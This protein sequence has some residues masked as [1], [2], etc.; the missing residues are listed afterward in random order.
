MPVSSSPTPLADKGHYAFIFPIRPGETRFQLSYR[1]PYTGS[2]KFQPHVYTPTET[3]AVM[4]PKGMSF[5]QGPSSGYQPDNEDV[6]VQTFV[7]K[8][9]SPS[10]P[11]DFTVSG[12]G[13]MPRE[14]QAGQNQGAET[15]ANQSGS[16]AT[17]Q[18]A[19]TSTASDTRPGGG[20]GAP[21]DSPDP[22]KKYRG[23]ILGGLSIVLAGAAAFMLRGKPA[24]APLGQANG[25]LPA[26]P[27]SMQ[28]AG[29]TL[30][31]P[32]VLPG[33]LGALKDELFTLETERLEGKIT[34]AEYAQAKS[35]L[36]VVLR[37]ALARQAS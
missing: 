13:S 15:A 14:E 16:D 23:W 17:G 26:K 25:S 27:L 35:A 10:Q 30:S 1:I 5:V 12:T 3:V 11:L 28:P 20:L 32:A 19:P 6:N 29:A 36:E 34:D 22:L 31:Q 7:A 24:E 8:N 18:G 2:Y 21:L 33:L 9:V 37:R 4:L